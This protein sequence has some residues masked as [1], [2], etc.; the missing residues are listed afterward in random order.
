[1]AFVFIIHASPSC[2]ATYHAACASVDGSDWEHSCIQ[3]T[4]GGTEESA[5]VS[6]DI[7]R[8]SGMQKRY[9]SLI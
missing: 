5:G 2:E 4:A 1:M 8:G 7:R 3:I 6:T 9:S